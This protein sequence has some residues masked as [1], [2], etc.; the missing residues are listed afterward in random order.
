MKPGNDEYEEYFN[1]EIYQTT[2]ERHM[3]SMN[4]LADVFHMINHLV[5]FKRTCQSKPVE[6]Q[7]PYICTT[8][9]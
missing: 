1:I 5:L 6:E 9:Q 7:L 4:V 2:W 8:I 3:I